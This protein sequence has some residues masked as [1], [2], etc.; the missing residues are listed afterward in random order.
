MKA[1]KTTMRAWPP[2]FLIAVTLSYL[3]QQVAK[4]FGIDLPDQ[5]QVEFVR[6]YAGWNLTF[7][8]IVVQV[9]LLL[10]AIEEIVFRWLIWMLPTRLAR[11]GR[12]SLP[13]AVL[14]SC[15]FT[16]V[17]YIAQPFPDSAFIALFFF[18]LAQCWLY[19]RTGRLWCAI[20]NHMLF[21]L[22]NLVLLFVL[23][24]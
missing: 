12:Y 7:A 14:S 2:I 13:L 21:N 15:V 16:A 9:V 18:G 8:F 5:A 23:P 1:L 3:T 19:R 6:Q 24:G 20:L 11:L 4:L 17:H 22:T 10:P